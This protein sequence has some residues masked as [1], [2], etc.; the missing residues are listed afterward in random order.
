[1]KF[2]KTKLKRCKNCKY[3]K[4]IGNLHFCIYN[5]LYEKYGY[6]ALRNYSINMF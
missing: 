5:E 1:M 2:A 4:R 6:E 3:Y